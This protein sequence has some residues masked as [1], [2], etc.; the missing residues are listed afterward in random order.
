MTKPEVYFSRLPDGRQLAYMEYGDPVGLPVI[1]FHGLPASRFEAGILDPAARAL[2]IRIVAPERPGFG[3]SEPAANRSLLEH[4]DDVLALTAALGIERFALFGMSAGGPHALACASRAGSRVTRTALVGA[5][6]PCSQDW[7][8]AD[9]RLHGR[10][11][12]R[13]ARHAP[14][15][16]WPSYGLPT[17]IAMRYFPG[18]TLKAIHAFSPT[19]DRLAVQ[20]PWIRQ[21]LLRSMS[22]SMRQGPTPALHELTL[23]GRDWGFRLQDVYVPVQLWHGSADQVVPVSHAHHYRQSLPQVEFTLL[24]GESHFSLPI[25][26]AFAILD[27]LKAPNS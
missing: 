23:L 10:T 11:A 24:P 21:Q 4:A 6:G 13:L 19:A 1:Y 7:A 5:L 16:L 20:E 17:M 27:K 14:A 25:N 18:F 15:L 8:R 9:L 2:G 3:H 26:H 22:E 12:F